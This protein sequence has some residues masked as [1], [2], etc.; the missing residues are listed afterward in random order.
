M[1][2]HNPPQ[3]RWPRLWKVIGAGAFVILPP[4]LFFASAVVSAIATYNGTCPGIMDIPPYPCSLLDYIA[5][6]TISPFALMTHIMVTLVWG[7]FA[8]GV[9]LFGVLLRWLMRRSVA[10][11]T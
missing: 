6:S 7:G 3:Q 10:R 9:L 8:L 4:L 11:R 5:R 1:N 2:N